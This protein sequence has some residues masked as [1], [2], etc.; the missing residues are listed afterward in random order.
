MILIYTNKGLA[1]A[2]LAFIHTWLIKNRVGYKADRW[3]DIDSC[4]DQT[5][6]KWYVKVPPD[7][8]VLNA[9]IAKASER[10]QIPKTGVTIADKLPDKLSEDWRTI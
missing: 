5:G 1:T 10:L 2:Q 6:T 3:A 4:A 7:Y 9:G 8:E